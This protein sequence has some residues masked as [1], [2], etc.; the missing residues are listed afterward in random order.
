MAEISST[1]S[2]DRMPWRFLLPV[3]AGIAVG[4]AVLDPLITHGLAWS[5]P[6]FGAAKVHRLFTQLHPEEVPILGSSRADGSYVPELIH[7]DAWNY[8]IEQTG[9]KVT[10]MMLAEELAKPKQG[11][12]II[13]FDHTFFSPYHPNIAHFI[14]ELRQPA[15]AACFADRLHWYNHVPML[16]YF[17][18]TDEYAKAFL[19]RFS[20]GTVCSKGGIFV[21]NT[22]APGELAQLVQ[23]RKATRHAWIP[24]AEEEQAWLDLLASTQRT[25]VVVVAPYHHTYLQTDNNPAAVQAYLD[26]MEALPHVH[27]IDLSAMP[28]PDNCFQNTTHVNWTGAVRFSKEL[29]ARLTALGLVP[30]PT[31]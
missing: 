3:L 19:A 25:M 21:N 24:H 16:R 17:G 20:T 31:E 1:S 22:A 26:R 23:Q 7:P 2:S 18:V 28:L 29:R 9:Y 14:P 15:V 10:R 6:S 5:N 27:V 4:C 11:P 30:L 13:N 8:G 12:V